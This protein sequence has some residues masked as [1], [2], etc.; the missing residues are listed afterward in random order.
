MLS[1]PV[2]LQPVKI[3][4]CLTGGYDDQL[5]RSFHVGGVYG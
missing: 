3:G 1:H 4:E 5:Q 2:L